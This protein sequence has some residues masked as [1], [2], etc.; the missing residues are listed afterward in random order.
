MSL[1]NARKQVLVAAADAARLAAMAL[2]R[3]Q[4]ADAE[5]VVSA[6]GA[7]V[8]PQ[9]R[10]GW[11]AR[12][13]SPLSKQYEK[14]WVAAPVAI[15]L[16]LTAGALFLAHW[17]QF[18]IF[19]QHIRIYSLWGPYFVG[20]LPWVG[21]ALVAAMCYRRL[22]KASA[23]HAVDSRTVCMVAGV[24]GGFIVALQLLTGVLA[25]FGHSPFA[26][27]PKWLLIN[28][29]FAG[30]PLVA[31][32]TGRAAL[33]RAAGTRW[34]TLALL[35]TSL[36]LAAIQF[37]FAQFSPEGFEAHL[38]FWGSTF[39][40]LV[41]TGLLAGF[42]VLYGGIRAGLLVSAPLAIFTYYSPILPIAPWTTIALAGVAGPAMGL[43]VAEGL[44]AQS[45]EP[46]RDEHRGFFSA[47]SV[48]WVS[49]AVIG[50][51]IF[52]FSFGFFGFRPSFT[53][54]GSMEPSIHIADVV[55]TGPVAPD[56]I[57][58]GDVILYDAGGRLRVLHRVVGIDKDASGRRVF[59]FKGDNNN[60]KDLL[61][62]YDK[63]IMGK[64]IGRIPKAGW[65]PIK[66]NQAIGSLR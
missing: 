21:A 36:G 12:Y 41:A 51:A 34:I 31:I 28:L 7:L 13:A 14:A 54:S 10:L 16:A 2:G 29:F 64:Y 40:P 46:E 38:K 19:P 22:P 33:L 61:P 47:P 32:E 35:G 55:L 53:P 66:F 26:H 43:W 39:I 15:A 20:V 25:N 23:E 42:F 50:L 65:L 5:S 58:V 44:F 52:W 48:A 45:E 59:T 49:T 63:Q 27:T 18:V 8:A 62:V 1:M 6:D 60:T 17:W 3:K 30:A 57:K 56:Q 9:S 37:S 11:A 4:R 24:V